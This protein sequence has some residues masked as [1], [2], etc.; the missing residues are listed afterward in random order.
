MFASPAKRNGSSRLPV[1][2]APSQLSRYEGILTAQPQIQ[3]AL[4]WLDVEFV[5]QPAAQLPFHLCT[6]L[7]KVK[8]TP[9]REW[10][11]AQALAHGWS[12]NLLVMQIET[13]L[14]D[15]QGQ[16]VLGC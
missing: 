2:A 5:Q 4:D 1:P 8:N 14:H 9:L 11:A 13:R 3:R 10:Y 7:D 6:L 16:A 12:R 15:R